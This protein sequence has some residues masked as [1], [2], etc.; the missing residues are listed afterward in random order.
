MDNY[1]SNYYQNELTIL[2]VHIV[3][4]VHHEIL[5]Q[6]NNTHKNVILLKLVIK[7]Y[8][9]MCMCVC[10]CVCVWFFFGGGGIKNVYIY[11]Y[12]SVDN[13]QNYFIGNL[14]VK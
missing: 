12:I 5:W 6:L 11:I 7:K 14:A 13:T 8:T 4:Y 9:I 1:L 10:M 2:K 3:S